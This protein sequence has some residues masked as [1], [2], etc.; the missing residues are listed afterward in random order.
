MFGHELLAHTMKDPDC[1]G[2]A[3]H[4]GYRGLE[5]AVEVEVDVRLAAEREL[6]VELEIMASDE[7]VVTWG[8]TTAHMEEML[9]RAV[10]TRFAAHEVSKQALAKGLSVGH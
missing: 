8:S 10:L 7:V 5:D 6:V 3:V 1:V 4:G 9:S 2:C